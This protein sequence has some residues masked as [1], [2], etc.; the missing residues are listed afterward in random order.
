MDFCLNKKKV[1]YEISEKKLVSMTVHDTIFHYIT[2]HLPYIAFQV[3]LKSTDSNTVFVKSFA[4]FLDS[5]A[6]TNFF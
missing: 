2:T 1:H 6:F 5:V 3:S 4:R